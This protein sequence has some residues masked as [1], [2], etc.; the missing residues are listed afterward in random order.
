MGTALSERLV[1]QADVL[2]FLFKQ[3]EMMPS[4]V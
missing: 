3:L 2:A 4:H 1:E